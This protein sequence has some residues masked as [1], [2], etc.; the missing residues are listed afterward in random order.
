MDLLFLFFAYLNLIFSPKI[1]TI[2]FS[3]L[4]SSLAIGLP[5]LLLSNSLN[6]LHK[7]FQ[8]AFQSLSPCCQPSPLTLLLFVFLK[9]N[10]SF[11]N[12]KEGK[13]KIHLALFSSLGRMLLSTFVME[14]LYLMDLG[15]HIVEP[16]YDMTIW[17]LSLNEIYIRKEYP[18]VS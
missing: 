7:I 14:I 1:L 4:F 13:K 18:Y 2:I 3:P 9:G 8:K 6:C 15:L 10:L 12:L 11:S 16:F 17:T 5:S